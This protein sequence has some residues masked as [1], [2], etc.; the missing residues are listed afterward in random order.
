LVVPIFA[1][2]A[3]LPTAGLACVRSGGQSVAHSPA[4]ALVVPE[5]FLKR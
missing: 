1:A 3:P 4:Q 2:F 5:S